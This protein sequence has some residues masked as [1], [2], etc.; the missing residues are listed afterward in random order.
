[1]GIYKKQNIEGFMFGAKRQIIANPA[2]EDKTIILNQIINK[3]DSNI[4]M[5]WQQR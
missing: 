1:M 4:E 5:K 2:Q 3:R